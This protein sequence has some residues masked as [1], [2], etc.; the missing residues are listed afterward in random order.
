MKKDLAKMP[1]SHFVRVL[2][3]KCKSDQVI[4]NKAATAVKCLNCGEDLTIPCGGKTV[5]KGKVLEQLS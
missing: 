1:S 3:K 4:Y 5:I 2:C